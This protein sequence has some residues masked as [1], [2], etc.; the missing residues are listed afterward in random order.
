MGRNKFLW[1]CLIVFCSV[2][3]YYSS[4]IVLAFYDL[5]S[6]DDLE[7]GVFSPKRVLFP[8][9]LFVSLGSDRTDV[10]VFVDK[11][12]GSSVT[13]SLHDPDY[14]SQMVADNYRLLVD[15]GNAGEG[16]QEL[17]RNCIYLKGREAIAKKI[18][19]RHGVLIQ[20]GK[21]YLVLVNHDSKLGIQDFVL[22]LRSLCRV[23]IKTDYAEF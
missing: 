14:F 13:F 17:E 2:T 23:E 18:K 19:R 16:A 3:A 1:C 22:S 8:S 10:L 20:N 11:E 4:N 15:K 21:Q 7:V 9:D 12:I 5:M 6:P